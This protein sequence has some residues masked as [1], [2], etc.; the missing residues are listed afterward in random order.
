LLACCKGDGTHI[1]VYSPF[2]NIVT[3]AATGE[4]KPN[5]SLPK[6]WGVPYDFGGIKEVK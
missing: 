5:G 6:L 3:R 2:L 1:S 4:R